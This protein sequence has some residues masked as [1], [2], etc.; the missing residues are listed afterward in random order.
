MTIYDLIIIG[1]GPAGLTA[2]RLAACR[3]INYLILGHPQ[4][5]QIYFAIATAS[6]NLTERSLEDPSAPTVTPYKVPARDIVSRL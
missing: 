4:K 5:S 2:A 1:A 6:S 3:K